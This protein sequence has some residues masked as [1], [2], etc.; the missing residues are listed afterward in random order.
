MLV[1]VSAYSFTTCIT[2]KLLSNAN[3][4]AVRQHTHKHHLLFSHKGI[5]HNILQHTVEHVLSTSSSI[6]SYLVSSALFLS[7]SDLTS[8]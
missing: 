1:V 6:K 3:S 2:I 8:L 4:P 5:K 7:G